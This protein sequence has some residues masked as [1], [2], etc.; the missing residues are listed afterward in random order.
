MSQINKNFNNTIN[1]IYNTTNNL[2]QE[3][4]QTF[5]NNKTSLACGG[6]NQPNTMNSHT[7]IG[8]IPDDI[9]D[10]LDEIIVSSSLSPLLLLFS[11]KP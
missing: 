4:P 11:Q 9:H 8:I 10:D 2:Q 7:L 5:L 3:Q 1:N 6:K